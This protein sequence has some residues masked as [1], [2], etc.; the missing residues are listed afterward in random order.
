MK[1]EETIIRRFPVKANNLL[2]KI[3]F[4]KLGRNYPKV[5]K[6]NNYPLLLFSKKKTVLYF[7]FLF[8]TICK[9]FIIKNKDYFLTKITLKTLKLK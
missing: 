9:N 7:L 6:K 2:K 4:L 8:K 5:Q 3:I 1:L